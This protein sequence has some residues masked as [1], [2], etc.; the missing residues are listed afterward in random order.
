MGVSSQ[1][2]AYLPSPPRAYLSLGPVTI[3]FYALCIIVGAA[4]GS[5]LA[6]RRWE[7]RGG[8]R[9]DVYG[10]LIWAL[11]LGLIGARLYHVLTDWQL[12]FGPN[13]PHEPLDALKIW[14]GGLGIWGAV[15]VGGLGVALYCR[16]HHLP[17][18]DMADAAAPGLVLAQG[19]GR[20]GNWFNQELYGYPTTVPWGLEIYERVEGVSTGELIGTYHPT[21]LYEMVWN[22]LVVLLLLLLDKKLVLGYGR[23]FASYVALYCLGRFWIELMRS[24]PATLILGLRVNTWVSGLLFLGGLGYVLV[25]RRG[26]RTL[27]EIQRVSQLPTISQP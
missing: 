8:R 7:A 22:F 19:I 23:L 16:K 13:A 1:L 2:V 9:D 26:R 14:Q 3:H 24:D 18:G 20:L 6:A 25:A 5:V 10:A 21:F 27:A 17:L 12:Y 15:L 11:P 4:A